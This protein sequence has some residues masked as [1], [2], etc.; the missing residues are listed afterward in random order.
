MIATSGHTLLSLDPAL[1]PFYGV[2]TELAELDGYVIRGTQRVVI[3]SSLQSQLIH[4]ASNI[5]QSIVKTKQRLREL[6]WWPVMDSNVEAASPSPVT[7][8]L[9]Q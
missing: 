8:C 4:L 9:S 3:S 7:C 6:N 1:L 5:Y 2:R